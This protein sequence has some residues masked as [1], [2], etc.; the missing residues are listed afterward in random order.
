VLEL[1]VGD[2]ETNTRLARP[3]CAVITNIGPAHLEFHGTIKN[4][5][6]KKSRIFHGVEDGG[7]AI[8]NVDTPHFDLMERRARDTGLRVITFGQAPGSD[9]H[10][11]EFDESSGESTV[12]AS[13]FE[14]KYRLQVKGL[15]MALNSMACI[16]TA[17]GFGE[18]LTSITQRLET[19]KPL[20]G[21]G[22]EHKLMI[23]GKKIK[24][25][26]DSYNANPVSMTASIVSFRQQ[27]SADVSSRSVFIL[28]DML[29]LGANSNFY[30][31]E[32]AGVILEAKPD[33]VLLVGNETLATFD[34]LGA[35]A[36]IEA[37][38]FKSHEELAIEFSSIVT[39]GDNILVK[40]SHG[41]NLHKFVDLLRKSSSD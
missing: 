23:S 19:F 3:H 36:E 11:V 15:H 6:V 37:A 21:R 8:L 16:A 1:A 28:G 32:L 2:M 22:I 25:I 30:H 26:D 14:F 9:V 40:G 12:R 34:E 29:E 17:V 18:E 7:L 31:R 5:A 33:L 39:E 13:D 27:S 20:P 35:G 4:I 24:V 38:H 10:L 41:S